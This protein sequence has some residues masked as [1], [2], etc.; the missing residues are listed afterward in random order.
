MKAQKYIDKTLIDQAVQHARLYRQYGDEDCR[1]ALVS[2]GL[3]LFTGI[4]VE[5]GWSDPSK[6]Y[7]PRG[8]LT[9]LVEAAIDDACGWGANWNEKMIPGNSL[10]DRKWRPR[11]EELREC[12][13]ELVVGESGG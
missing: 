12:L 4:A 8:L 6:D 5:Q 3:V 9:T 10:Q 13:L 1:R 7:R 2:V 11:Y